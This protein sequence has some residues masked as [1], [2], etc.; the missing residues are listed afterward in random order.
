MGIE[1]CSAFS[2]FFSLAMSYHLAGTL[3][4]IL[5]QWND[6]FWSLLIR[7]SKMGSNQEEDSGII[8]SPHQPQNDEQ[9]LRIW[10]S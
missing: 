7:S 10:W 8:M 9:S 2:D 1:T 5:E 6:E 3:G 4:G